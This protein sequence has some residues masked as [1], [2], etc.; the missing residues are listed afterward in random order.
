[1]MLIVVALVSGVDSKA[2]VCPSAKTQR[3]R[4]ADKQPK[5]TALLYTIRALG[6]TIGISSA[7]SIQLSSLTHSLRNVFKNEPNASQMI[8]AILHSKSA[9]RELPPHLEQAAIDAY[10]H[11]LS[12]VWVVAG[13]VAVLTVISSL[14]IQEKDVGSKGEETGGGVVG[15]GGEG[16]GGGTVVARGH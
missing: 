12:A 8:D 5:A 4:E 15:D 3:G 14:F 7:G 1:M 9:I 10:A 16:L 6:G 2:M 11:S 13:S